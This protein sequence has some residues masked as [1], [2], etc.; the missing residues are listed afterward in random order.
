[1][2]QVCLLCERTKLDANLYCQET[3]CPAEMSPTV[4]D[5]GEWVGDIEI[6]KP[7]MVLRSAVLYKATHQ[8]K[9]VFLKVAHPGEE[10]KERLKREAEFLRD[11][12]LR[13][14]QH[15]YLPKLLPPYV[16]TTLHKDEQPYGRIVLQGHLLYFYLFEAFDG[17]PLRDVITQNPQLWIFHVGWLM[18]SVSSAVAY[19]QSK[20]SF[21]YA[22]S[23]ETVLVRF[24]DD[25]SAPRVLLMDLGIA[26]TKDELRDS[27]Y[28]FFVPPAYTAPELIGKGAPPASYATD[29]YGLGLVLYELLV[30]EPAYTFKLSNDADVFNAIM[31]MNR[32]RMNRSEDLPQVA[33]IAVRAVSQEPGRRFQNAVEFVQELEG[34]FGKVPA[35]KKSRIPSL[36]TILRAV[37]ILLGLGFIIAL[38]ITF[39]PWAA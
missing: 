39:A 35:I 17:E 20:G 34:Y 32:T 16:N 2:K 24:D 27:W 4:L 38:I 3:F 1:M 6:V 26:C 30:G 12:Q 13:G 31:R 9:T 5:Y 21:H 11:M 14:E 36:H 37:A 23:P 7:I 18:I 10:N 29:V 25:P 33:Q 8:N 19:M 15:R 22:I 28:R